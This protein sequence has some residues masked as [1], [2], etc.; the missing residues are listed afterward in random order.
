MQ[1]I[2]TVTLVLAFTLPAQ[3]A[4][5][6]EPQLLMLYGPGSD[7][8]TGVLA[9]KLRRRMD[10]R[11]P[12]PQRTKPI[13]EAVDLPDLLRPYGDFLVHECV[14]DP[15][16]P[17]AVLEQIEAGMRE[18]QT[19]E[20]APAVAAFE[21]A[22]AMLPCL[23]GYLPEGTISDL[24]FF[25][26]I[27]AF[28]VVDKGEARR[29]FARA[30]SAE[31]SRPWDDR[32]APPPQQAFLDAGKEIL[33]T[34]P[35]PLTVLDPGGLAL[36]LRIDS[37]EWVGYPETP[38]ELVPGVHLIQWCLASGDVR[39]LQVEV[40]PGGQLVLLTGQG[41]VEAVLDGGRDADLG[42]VIAPTLQQYAIEQEADQLIIVRV[43]EPAQMTLFDPHAGTFER[44]ERERFQS[45]VEEQR[46]RWGPRGG[47]SLGIGFSTISSPGDKWD[48]QYIAF[49]GSAEFR[50]LAGIYLDVEAAVRLR[51][52]EVDRDSLVVLPSTR[53]GVKYAI[54]LGNMRPY[55]GFAGQTMVFG[56]T[57]SLGGGVL[58]GMAIDSPQ[59][60]ALRLGIDVFG[61]RVG[62]WVL[63]VVGQIGFYY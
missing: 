25:H 36:D 49:S 35:R 52:G 14:G 51:R 19:L 12:S 17:D 26:G 42:R 27:A 8:G 57:T 45:S 63:Q 2:L 44:T 24:Y 39:S 61:G 58:L 34:P 7:V 21:R 20:Y 37:A 60:P 41:L 23:T 6:A 53:I 54:K 5:E 18:F 50:V 55:L 29:Q 16:P 22:E 10:P 38:R 47:M 13:R 1:G 28:Y 4:D 40:V 30:L 48:F 46:A 62:N 33:H 9:E 3:A 31:P 32:F 11:G 43:G 15:A 56:D 59:I